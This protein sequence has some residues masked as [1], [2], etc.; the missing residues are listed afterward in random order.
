MSSNIARIDDI[1]R[2]RAEAVAALIT[3]YSNVNS[4]PP[5]RLLDLTSTELN[6]EFDRAKSE[7]DLHLMVGLLAALEAHFRQDFE[8]RCNFRL[9]D[10]LSRKFRT[11]RSSRKNRVRLED[12]IFEAWKDELPSTRNL[13]SDL[14]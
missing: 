10:N 13:T 4:S 11:L 1:G 6:L 8:R 5:G 9:K 12:D 14:K 7:L 2:L 3:F